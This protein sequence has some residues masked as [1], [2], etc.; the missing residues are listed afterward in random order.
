MPSR[1]TTIARRLRREQTP[2]ETRV[3]ACLRNRGLGG[4]RWKRQQPIPPYVADF[5]CPDLKLIVEIDGGQHSANAEADAAR[6][7][8]LAAQGY[9][10]I[11]FW[12]Y[13][14]LEDL[15]AVCATILAECT[16]L[17]SPV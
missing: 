4:H 12:N 17:S 11:R 15:D 10:L 6:T 14:V 2:A 16:R 8:Y 9:R 5:L 7:A 1:L 13:E 3:W